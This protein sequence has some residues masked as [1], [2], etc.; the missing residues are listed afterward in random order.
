MIKITTTVPALITEDVY[1]YLLNSRYSLI[2]S[3]MTMFSLLRGGLESVLSSS[4]LNTSARILA[5]ICPRTPRFSSVSLMTA[6][7]TNQQ[8]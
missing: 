6:R 8:N 4:E 2:S 5:F 3:L 1:L 7:E